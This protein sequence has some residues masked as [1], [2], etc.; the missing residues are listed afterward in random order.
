[1]EKIRVIITNN[2]KAV[3][4][5]TG[6]RMIDWRSD[7]PATLVWAEAQDGGDP[8]RAAEI[9]D[10]VLM[11]AAPFDKPPQTL[12]RLG[13]RFAG[14]YWGRED[15]ALALIQAAAHA[16]ADRRRPAMRPAPRAARAPRPP[17]PPASIRS[18]R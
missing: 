5:P 3:K 18:S 16:G 13:S 11:Q 8:A 2:Q 12:A 14:A 4:V 9:R 10:A 15:L 6:V 1:M 17:R 7:A